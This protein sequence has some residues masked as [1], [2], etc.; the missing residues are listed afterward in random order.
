MAS[1]VV[2]VLALELLETLVLVVNLLPILRTIAPNLGVEVHGFNE[3]PTAFSPYA[4]ISALFGYS[5]A[6]NLHETSKG[7]TNH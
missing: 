1:L 6:R 7:S 2:V 3:T 4:I 5:N